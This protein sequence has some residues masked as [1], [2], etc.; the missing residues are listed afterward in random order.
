M[1]G[2][3]DLFSLVIAMR[4]LLS[5][6]SYL[7]LKKKITELIASFTAECEIINEPDL[8][9]RMGFPPNWKKITRYKL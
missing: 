5:K 9:R 7:Q 4:Y 2:K 1:Y 3:R 8:L 6:E